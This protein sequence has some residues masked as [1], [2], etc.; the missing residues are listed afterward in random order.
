MAAGYLWAEGL[1]VGGEG[2]VRLVHYQTTIHHLQ[3]IELTIQ[4]MLRPR[5]RG[6]GGGEHGG[7]T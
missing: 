5:W 6:E 1:S 3:Q 7:C 4:H 2:T